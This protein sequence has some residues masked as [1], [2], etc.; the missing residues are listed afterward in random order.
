MSFHVSSDKDFA[1]MVLPPRLNTAAAEQL[2]EAFLAHR[3]SQLL[4]RADAVEQVGGLCLQVLLSAR[5]T[6]ARD[7]CA[8][9]YDGMSE[10][11]RSDLRTLGVDPQ[12]IGN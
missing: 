8:L 12:T 10:A 3:G 2:R 5:T 9:A 11:F 7:N 4:V 6:W 1:T